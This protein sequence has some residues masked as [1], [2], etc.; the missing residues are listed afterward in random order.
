MAGALDG[1]RQR[2]LMPGAGA[3]LAARLDLAALRKVAAKARDVLVINFFNVVGAEVAN[4][5]ARA[6]AAA[7]AT[8]ATARARR[9]VTTATFATFAA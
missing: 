9:A 4:L 2:T 5:A 1:D 8:A 7:T 6:K 3:E